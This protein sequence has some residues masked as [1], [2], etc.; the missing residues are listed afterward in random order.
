MKT[1]IVTGSDGY[2][3]WPLTLK[4]LRKGNKVIGIDNGYRRSWVT[5]IGSKSAIPILNMVDREGLLKDMYGD[6]FIFKFL[7]LK[8]PQAIKTIIE[9]YNPDTI[10][11]LASQ[12]SAPYSNIDINYCNFTQ[13]NNTQM[14]RNIMWAIKDHN[15]NIHLIVTTTT[16]IYG[17]PDFDIPEGNLVINKDEIPFPSMGGSWYHMSRA[18]DASNLWLGHRQFKLSIS[19]LRTSIVC[20]TS[21]D[22]TMIKPEYKTRFDVDFYFGVVV[23][24]F[25]SQALKER[26]LTVYG[27]GLQKKPMISLTDMVESTYNCFKNGA[28]TNQYKIY[29]QLEKEISIVDLANTIKKY[30]EQEFK[31]SVD[32]LHIP[33]PRVENEEHQ[34]TIDNKRFLEELCN[35]EIKCTLTEAI[36]QMCKDLY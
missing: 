28:E 19:E 29:N 4:L 34:M 20:G 33:N 31:I 9:T 24:R 18:H 17:A 13:T 11:H 23:N 6:R 16:G 2:C 12:P 32:V 7:D 21:T 14:L 26:K 5:D 8:Q 10:I 22:L 25:V 27:K 35:G 30:C 1:V 36:K 15:P 3:G